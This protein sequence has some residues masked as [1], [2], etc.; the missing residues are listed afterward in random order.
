MT[1]SVIAVLLIALLV[2]G[3]GV[4]V[5]ARLE[6]GATSSTAAPSTP[7]TVASAL[8]ASPTTP[9][10][11]ST[12]PLNEGSQPSSTAMVT[13]RKGSVESR[14]G[15]GPWQA[16]DDGA[17]LSENDVVRTGRRAEVEL[18]FGEQ[19]EVRLSP[20]SELTIRDLSEAVSRIRLDQGHVT[21]VVGSTGQV[22]RVQV[23]NTDAEV[24]SERG[25]FG[26]ATDGNGQLA[27]AA[28]T[29]RVSVETPKAAVDVAEG[30]FTTVV[31]DQAPTPPTAL[32]ASLFLKVGA[33]AA[34]QTNQAATTVRGTTAPGAVVRIGDHVAPAD[35]SGSFAVK[36]PLREGLNELRVEVVDAAGRWQDQA[37]PPITV[38]RS[39]P[40]LD[41]AIQ[42]GRR[43]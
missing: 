4:A 2:V 19:I 43:E 34:T 31:G 24:R 25:A 23:R 28:T 9:A 14:R 29:G 21:A 10:L 39:K 42:W 17:V 11:P 13:M 12:A 18:R 38:D 8:A 26:L 32:P 36:V 35:A 16:L 37:L 3:V 15:A 41:A 5:S 30:Q 1:R 22:L 33:L 6:V 20:R 27:V 7:P 40:P